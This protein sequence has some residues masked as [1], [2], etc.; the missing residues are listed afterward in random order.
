MDS[1]TTP[2]APSDSSPAPVPVPAL[3]QALAPA[4]ASAPAAGPSDGG[5]PAH[6]VWDW[7]GTLLHDIDVVLEA[8]NACFAE[9]DLPQLT[10]EQ[11]REMF[12]VPIPAFY[13]RVLGRRPGEEEYVRMDAAFHRHYF[14]RA[15]RAGLAEGAAELLVSWGE[16]GGTHSL[17]SLAPHQRLRSWVSELGI[18]GHFVRVDGDAGH[19][20]R[21]G[22]ARQMARHVAALAGVDRS[23]TVVIGDATDDALAAAHAGVRAVLHTGGSHSRGSLEAAGVPVVDSLAEAVSLAAELVRRPVAPGPGPRRGTPSEQR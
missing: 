20:P 13:E 19:G 21:T 5:G 2:Q 8:T 4:P 7:N 22:K 11:Y 9:L 23:R 6:I 18:D 1:G 10:L 15:A 3:A 16:D 14:S 12:C 17:C